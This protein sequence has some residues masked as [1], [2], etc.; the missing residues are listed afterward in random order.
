MLYPYEHYLSLLFIKGYD[1]VVI[2]QRLKTLRLAPMP[3]DELEDKRNEV[4]S[5]MPDGASKLLF[6]KSKIN[7]PEFVDKYSDFL[8]SLDIEDVIPTLKGQR[9]QA[10]DDAILIGADSTLRIPVQGLLLYGSTNEE[11]LQ[12]LSLKYGCT[13]TDEAIRLFTKYFWN[14]SRMSRLEIYN[15]IAMMDSPKS[16]NLLLDA[17]HKKPEKIKWRLTGENIL[18]LEAILKEIMNEAFGKFQT[19]VKSEDTE[20]VHR[21]TKWADLAIKAAEK[22]DKIFKQNDKS[23]LQVLQFKLDK[24]SQSDITPKDDL[25]DDVV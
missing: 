7:L 18:T 1:N 3:D 24:K 10:W 22:F 4:F 23:L 16:R 2:R 9:N 11:I 19:A 6:P 15:Y 17:F 8:K 5:F 20:S 13:T 25:K 21:V 14:I 12:V